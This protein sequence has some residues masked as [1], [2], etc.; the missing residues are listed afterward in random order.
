MSQSKPIAVRDDRRLHR[1]CSRRRR[2]RL[3]L[4]HAED[5]IDSVGDAAVEVARA[6]ARHDH[7][8]D[9]PLRD[10]VGQWRPR[11]RS[12]PRCRSSRSSSRRSGSR[13]RRRAPRPIFHASATRIPYCSIVSGS[14]GRHDQHRHLAALRALERGEPAPRARAA[15]AGVERAREVGD[16]RARA[17]APATS[18]RAARGEQ[19]RE[20]ERAREHERYCGAGARRG[21]SPNS[22]VGRLRDRLLASKVKLGLALEPKSS[23]SGWSGRS[24]RVLNSRTESM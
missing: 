12:R 20:S 18:R 5:A 7:V 24:A 3:A 1:R 22:T 10:R 13:R 23:R 21:A 19:Q 16:A 15:L 2:Q 8:V 9:D 14:R 4:D 6:E 17:R 11:G